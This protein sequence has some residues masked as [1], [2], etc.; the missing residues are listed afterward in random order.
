VS[1]TRRRVLR[2]RDDGEELRDV[3][4]ESGKG[5]SEMR[6]LMDKVSMTA[7]NRVNVQSAVDPMEILKRGFVDGR[8]GEAESEA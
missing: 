1:T 2:K 7:A 4:T 3:S 6:L 5:G 8:E